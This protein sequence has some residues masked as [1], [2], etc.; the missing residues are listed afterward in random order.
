MFDIAGI[1][2][3]Y[4]IIKICVNDNRYENK[5]KKLQK[6]GHESEPMCICNDAVV[7]VTNEKKKKKNQSYHTK[8]RGEN[9]QNYLNSMGRFCDCVPQN[10]CSRCNGTYCGKCSNILDSR[11]KLHC[12]SKPYEKYCKYC[13]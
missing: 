4:L 5:I 7:C 10:Y 2:I 13:M 11:N 8:R 3:A 12:K 6:L 1:L 9:M